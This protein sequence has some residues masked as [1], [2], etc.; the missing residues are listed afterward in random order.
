M[1]SFIEAFRNLKEAKLVECTKPKVA[2]WEGKF[3]CFWWYSEETIKRIGG[4]VIHG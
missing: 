1:K 3:Y 2:F 4:E